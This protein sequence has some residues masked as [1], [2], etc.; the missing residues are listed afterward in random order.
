MAF[1]LKGMGFG[2]GTGYKSPQMMKKEAAMKMKKEAAMKLKKDSAMDMKKDSA[3]KMKGKSAYKKNGNDKKIVN[4]RTL[5]KAQSAHQN[6][7][8]I[9]GLDKRKRDTT[10][11]TKGEGKYYSTKDIKPLKHETPE[12]F[13]KRK[14]SVSKYISK[15]Q[16]KTLSGDGPTDV[17]KIKDF[18]KATEAIH[19]VQHMANKRKKK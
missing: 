3:M 6:I 12:Q 15:K 1:K 11:G 5:T 7:R 17:G 4:T 2:E 13:K 19:A 18:E 14:K 16:L 9:L 10:M 8:N